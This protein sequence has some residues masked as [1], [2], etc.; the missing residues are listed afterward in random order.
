MITALN[1]TMGEQGN[2]FESAPGANVSWWS[3]CI[4]RG[5]VLTAIIHTSRMSLPDFAL[6]QHRDAVRS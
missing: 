1:A 4:D 2:Y 5:V 6:H 3:Q